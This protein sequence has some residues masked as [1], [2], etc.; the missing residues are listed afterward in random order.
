MSNLANGCDT[1]LVLKVEDIEK[2]LCPA[3]MD[4]L[5]EI[6]NTI[7]KGRYEDEKHPVNTYFICNKD[8]P[9]AKDVEDVILKG[10]EEKEFSR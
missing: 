4:S 2:Y 8:E 9:Y 3:Q 5:N 7:A 6:C 10:E 1:H